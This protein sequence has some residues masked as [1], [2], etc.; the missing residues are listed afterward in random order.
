MKVDAELY[1]APVNSLQPRRLRL[2]FSYH[3]L[4]VVWSV[5]HVLGRICCNTVCGRFHPAILLPLMMVVHGHRG[6]VILRV[7]VEERLA[8]VPLIETARRSIT[9]LHK[10]ALLLKLVI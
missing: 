9:Y 8:L 1:E 4:Q 7:S 3:L 6:T 10:R 5:D 2:L